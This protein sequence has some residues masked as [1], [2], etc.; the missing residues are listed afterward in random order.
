MPS[1]TE[2]HNEMM[3]LKGW[4][5]VTF[6]RTGSASLMHA[7]TGSLAEDYFTCRLEQNDPGKS[8]NFILWSLFSWVSNDTSNVWYY[9]LKEW[10]L[11]GRRKTV[12]ATSPPSP[13]PDVWGHWWSWSPP[14]LPPELGKIWW[15]LNPP[16]SHHELGVALEVVDLS[17]SSFRTGGKHWLRFNPQNYFQY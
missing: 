15:R 10:N 8:D 6:P 16:S 1:G 9:C 17:L 13:P 14:S 11:P 3:K 4:I 12:F 2:A 7:Y 5:E